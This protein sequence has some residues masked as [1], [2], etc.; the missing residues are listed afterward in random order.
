M[1]DINGIKDVALFLFEKKITTHIDTFDNN[2]Y[3][4]LIIELHETFL[5]LN[6]RMLG[7]TPVPFSQI[8]NI[9]RFRGGEI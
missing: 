9:D 1:S 6:D 2:F 5:V 4:G 8:K 7:E 3:N